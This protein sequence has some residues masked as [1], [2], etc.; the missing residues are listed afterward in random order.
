MYK[1]AIFADLHANL[2]ALEAILTKIDTL[3]VDDIISLGD[4]IAIGPHPDLCLNLMLKKGIKSVQGNHEEYILR[5]LSK[6]R[7]DSMG[8]GEYLHHLWT[9]DQLTKDHINYLATFPYM[10]EQKV[11]SLS[12]AFM[13][14][15]FTLSEPFTEF[16]NLRNTN[17]DK[18][19][20]AFSIYE[21]DVFSFG[22]SHLSLDLCLEKRYINPGSVGCHKG[23]Y[24]QFSVFAIGKSCLD[25]THYQAPYDKSK[26]VDDLV[27]KDVPDRELILKVFF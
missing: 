22:H 13:H 12:L 14:A 5:G 1:I 25:V 4:S 20:K 11:E 15:P 9:N 18:I 21:N 27:K 17:S 3:D 8:H 23:D 2:P 24:A 10:I 16:T 7:P 19:E 6:S 26:T